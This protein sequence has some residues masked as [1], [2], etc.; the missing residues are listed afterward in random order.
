MTLY[1]AL[2][3]PADARIMLGLLLGWMIW[4]A[5]MVWCYASG[6]GKQAWKRAGGFLLI[7]VVLNTVLFFSQG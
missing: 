4:A 5:V 6:S 7:T 1:Y 2:P 3:L